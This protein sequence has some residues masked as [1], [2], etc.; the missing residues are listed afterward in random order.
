MHAAEAAATTNASEAAVETT[1]TVEATATAVETSATPM[2]T[3]AATAAAPEGHRAGC[4]RCCKG[5]SHRARK[6][7]ISHENLLNY[8]PNE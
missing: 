8:F 7:P 1:A 4:H 3:A 2:T 5:Q 6:K